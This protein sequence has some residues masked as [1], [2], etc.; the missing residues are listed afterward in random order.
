MEM[1]VTVEW[2]KFLQSTIEVI[3]KKLKL[4]DDKSLIYT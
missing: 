2:S 1:K 3:T 4:F